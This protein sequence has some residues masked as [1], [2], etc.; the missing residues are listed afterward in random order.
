MVKKVVTC[1]DYDGNEYQETCWFDLSR[2]DLIEMDLEEKGFIAKLE[3]IAKSGDSQAMYKVFKNVLLKAYGVRPADN[4]RLF[5][6]NDKVREEFFQSPAYSEFLMEL[7]SDL[8]AAKDF[9]AGVV[10][11]I[12]KAENN[13][14][15]TAVPVAQ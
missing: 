8:D 9:F 15:I 3:G 2:A 11:T 4:P 12:P 6:K 7:M 1:K 10:N 5:V 13:A 14:N